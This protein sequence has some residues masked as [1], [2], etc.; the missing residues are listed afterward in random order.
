MKEMKIIKRSGQEVVFDKSKIVEAIRKANNEVGENHRIS[1]AALQAIV[2][3]V[4][5]ECAI[6][7]RSPHVEEIQDM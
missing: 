6:L 5:E 4:T 2:N 1:E 3:T 7:G